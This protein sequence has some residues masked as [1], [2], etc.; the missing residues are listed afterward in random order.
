MVNFND[1]LNNLN[2]E[3]VIHP[4][5]VFEDNIKSGKFQYLRS[6]QEKILGE[7]FSN[8]SQKDTIVKMNTGGGKTT[9]GLLQL[10]SSLN[11]GI[12]SAVFLCL[13]NQLVHQVIHAS[14]DLGINCVTFDSNSNTFPSDFLNGEAILVTTFKK[15]FNA[16]SIFG[17]HGDTSKEA[18]KIGA[19]VIDDAH[20]ALTQARD[21]FTL[22]I[23]SNTELYNNLLNI[24]KDALLHQAK[25]TAKDIF[26]QIDPYAIM[27]VPYWSWLDNIDQVHRFISKNAHTDDSIKFQWNLI[28]NYLELCDMFVSVNSIEISPKC[29]PINMI[30]SYDR[31]E[32]RIFMSATLNDDSSLIT[33]FNIGKKAIINPL[34]AD[35]F[36]DTGDKLI[37]APY[38]VDKSLNTEK[39]AETLDT[40]K[41]INTVVLVSSL[42]RAS[43]WTKKGYI[44]PNPQEI[45][46]TITSLKT[47]T[48]NKIVLSNRYDGIDLADNSC[49][50]LVLDGIPSVNNLSERFS[51]NSRPTSKIMQFRQ[52]QK[53]EQGL[54]RAVRSIND[55][56][57]VLLLGGD[58]IQK[59]S[60]KQFQ[61]FMTPQ[62]VSQIKLGTKVVEMIKKS[63]ENSIKAIIDAMN[64]VLTRD[65]SWIKVHKASLSKTLV[66]NKDTQ[67]IENSIFEREAFDLALS[68]QYRLASEK[69][70]SNLN[71]LANGNTS[72][73]GW[74]MQLAAYYLYKIDKSASSELQISAH[75]KNNGLLKPLNG[76][77]YQKII[78][79]QT[80][81]AYNIK[82]ILERYDNSNAIILY[83]DQVFTGLQF[84]PNSHTQFEKSF[85]DLGTLLG[86][87]TQ[88]PDN[89]F[90][91]GPDGLWDLFDNEFLVIEA[92]NEVNLNRES[93]IKSETA[94][95]SESINWFNHKYPNK[96]AF[97]LLIHPSIT[98]HAEAFGP[99]NLKILNVEK[100]EN[101]KSVIR[102]FYTQLVSSPIEQI[103]TQDIQKQ[104]LSFRLNSKSLTKFF[105]N[106]KK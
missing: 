49:R 21:S 45:G 75:R 11:E 68:N 90:N 86:F 31:A 27:M 91:E 30:P 84:A 76:L 42:N 101:F 9:V 32:R 81:Q 17:I 54:G 60:T 99:D 64:Q 63:N 85:A 29:L 35:S 98:L 4:K 48:N 8:R 52:A 28:K 59:I 25:G 22:K 12:S 2:K 5:E 50:I 18:I 58:L 20:A 46:A 24:F 15:L 44:K 14:K 92:K 83:I 23:P 77:Q 97:P 40:S 16:K 89:S 19:L 94:Q 6:G 78:K 41:G 106:P 74:Y 38:N 3:K 105:D 55:F 43:Y 102:N 65:V 104:I 100:L 51:L 33:D 67:I 88:Q 7:W 79:K 69:I 103:T 57:V 37:L 10:Q 1:L 39:I 71:K 47:Q 73:E 95:I 93:I 87:E 62:T 70:R 82:K 61:E 66:S 56:A 13:D 80:T 53:I 36:A 34:Q 72:E 96:Q 26:E